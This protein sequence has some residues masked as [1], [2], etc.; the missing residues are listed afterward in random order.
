MTNKK[1]YIKDE[2]ND[3]I[4]N[5]KDKHFFL[6]SRVLPASLILLGTFLLSSQVIY[7]LI[8]FKTNQKS[9]KIEGSVLGT[10]SGFKEFE[11]RELT[12]EKEEVETKEAPETFYLSIPKLR[13]EKA[14]VEVNAESLDPKEALGHYT[15]SKLPGETGN[16]FIYGHSV[17]PWFFNPQN[18][19]TIFSTLE[20]MEIG[21]KIYI[22]INNKK[23]TYT[24]E[25]KEIL[26]PEAVDPLKEFKP[27]FLNEDTITLMTCVPPGT[28]LK[29]LLVYAVKE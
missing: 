21:D 15:G 5:V 19:K 6:K 7:P 10:V 2:S 17:L 25:G 20:R 24:V 4:Y 11:F 28:K 8:Y 29:R 12:A 14:E 16:S 9:E 1:V 3:P 13:I 27:A 26:L 22:E 18:Y 23:L